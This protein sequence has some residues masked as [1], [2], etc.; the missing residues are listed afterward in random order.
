MWKGLECP[1]KVIDVKVSFFP[2]PIIPVCFWDTDLFEQ[3]VWSWYCKSQ[4]FN[5]LG[6]YNIG[7]E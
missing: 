1:Q 7:V 6:G 3:I 2:I 4:Y 5:I